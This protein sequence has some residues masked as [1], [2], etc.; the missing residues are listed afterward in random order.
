[1]RP[2][3]LPE[4]F[5]SRKPDAVAR[6]LLGKLL[7]RS[8]N[9]E[10][11]GGVIV[12]TE[13]Y[14]GL[15]DPA[16]RAFQGKKRYNAQMWYEPGRLFIYNVHKYWMLN[17]VAHEAG[18]VGG[19]L[20]RAIKPTIGLKAMRRLRPGVTDKELARGPGKLG[21]ALAITRDLIGYPVTD[22]DSPVRILDAPCIEEYGT[23][24]RI[25]V[26]KDL[27]VPLRYYILSSEFTS[28]S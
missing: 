10:R 27:P 6:D 20:F 16:S 8:L 7:I 3:V 9:G 5:Y 11:L 2:G 18:D 25:G 22:P 21:L 13:A 4:F 26:T 15:E 12:E 23:S 19:V 1:M 24:K 28:R 14:F 17:V